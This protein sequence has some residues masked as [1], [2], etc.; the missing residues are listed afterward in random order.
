MLLFKEKQKNKNSLRKYFT[1][2][3]NSKNKKIFSK[4]ILVI[5]LIIFACIPLDAFLEKI[6]NI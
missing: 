5:V 6:I 4:S 2:F 3:L 1:L